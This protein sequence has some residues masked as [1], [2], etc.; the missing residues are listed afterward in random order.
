MY[1]AA[2]DYLAPTSVDEALPILTEGGEDV[3]ILAGARA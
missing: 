2:F 1:P 3:K